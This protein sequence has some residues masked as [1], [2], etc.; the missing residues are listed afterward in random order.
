MTGFSSHT[1]ELTIN[2]R[3]VSVTMLIKSVNSRFFECI[4]K[5]PYALAVVETE[6]VK[7]I[8]ARLHRGTITVTFHITNPDVLHGTI[9]PALSSIEQ[10]V[11]A[12]GEIQNK[13]SLEGN[14]SIHD[15]L[16]LPNIFEPTQELADKQLTKDLLAHLDNALASLEHE[17]QREGAVL[18]K[19]LLARLAILNKNM[20]EI[21]TRSSKILKERKK[22]LSQELAQLSSALSPETKEQ[23]LLLLQNQLDKMDIHEEI[24]RFTAHL[25]NMHTTLADKAVE[26]GK[27][28]DFIVQEL[29]REINTLTAKCADTVISNLAISSKVELEKMREQIQNIV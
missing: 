4:C 3:S 20:Q 16:S 23:Q 28:L 25:Q 6:F 14:L 13:F 17:R 1:F 29:M 27:K 18:E 9:K 5:L 10:Y 11:K 22:Q 7:H 12:I 15:I 26:K 19:D 8:K 2:G 24:V 21:E